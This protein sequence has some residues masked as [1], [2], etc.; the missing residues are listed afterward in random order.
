MADERLGRMYTSLS[1]VQ[2]CIRRGMDEEA[3]YYA[4]YLV[5]D[6]FM[7]TLLN[8]LVVVA[9]EDVGTGS[10]VSSLYA[11]EAVKQTKEWYPKGPWVLS[12]VN[13]VLALSRASKSRDSDNLQIV[14]AHDLANNPFREPPDFCFDEHTLKG[15]KMG[16]STDFFYE[17]AAALADDVSTPDWRNRAWKTDLEL[18][19]TKQDVH[20]QFAGEKKP[21]GLSDFK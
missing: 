15:K 14:I 11:L 1:A 18:D 12:L 21:V 2:K 9:Y 3:V 10:M 19:R 6:G 13:A 5:K 20:G 8:R 16:R 17:T 7:T 4:F